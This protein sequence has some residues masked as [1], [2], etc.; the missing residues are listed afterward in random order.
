MR[1]VDRLGAVV[2]Q[3]DDGGLGLDA[4]LRFVAPATGQYSVQVMGVGV[5]SGSYHLQAED[6]GGPNLLLTG[7]LRGSDVFVVGGA[8]NDTIAAVA[9]TN[10]LRG[11]EGN[12]SL[13]GGSGFDSLNGNKGD[14]TLIGVS[15]VGDWLLGGQ[16]N[17]LIDAT[18]ASGHDSINGNIGADTIMGGPGGEMLRGGR[19][20]DVITGGAGADWLS[21]DRALNTL[22]GGGGADIF[23]AGPGTDVTTDFDRAQGDRVQIDPGV[24]YTLTQ[25]GADTLLDLGGGRMTLLGVQMSSLTGDW[26]F[27]A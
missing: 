24:T 11:G 6:E 1:V 16:G 23:H 27:T 25:V 20:D 13:L 21:G 15:Q 10:D 22:T 26:I 3:D 9:G 5:S 14:D 7:Q 2:A 19:G 4:H 12:D 17:D 8:G 18:G